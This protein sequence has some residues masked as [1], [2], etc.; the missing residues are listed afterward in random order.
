MTLL[1]TIT[2]RTLRRIRLFISDAKYA[3]LKSGS[4]VFIFIE[5]VFVHII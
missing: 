4:T 3:D 5:Y 1:Y 2:V